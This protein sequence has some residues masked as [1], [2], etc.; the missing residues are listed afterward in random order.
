MLTFLVVRWVSVAVVTFLAIAL[1]LVV[2][3][4]WIMIIHEE[5]DFTEISL[6]YI[7]AYHEYRAWQDQ[8][9][10]GPVVKKAQK[11]VYQTIAFIDVKRHMARHDVYIVHHK[12]APLSHCF[13]YIQWPI[14]WQQRSSRTISKRWAMRPW[15]RCAENKEC[16]TLHTYFF[17]AQ[18]D[19]M[20]SFISG[21]EAQLLQN[22]CCIVYLTSHRIRILLHVWCR[23]SQSRGSLCTFQS[24]KLRADVCT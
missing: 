24:P 20:S 13:Y 4:A 21:V 22:Q 9:E 5:E 3:L 10:G 8:N 7:M 12:G 23:N 1:A 16:L 2:V 17:Q 6:M 11:G 14:R 15:S 19:S 18:G